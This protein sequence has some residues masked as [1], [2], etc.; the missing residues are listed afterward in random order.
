MKYSGY[1]N[2]PLGKKIGLKPY[3]KLSAIHAPS[4][5]ATHFKPLPQGAAIHTTL[6]ENSDIVHA[7]Y[8]DIESLGKEYPRLVE[9]IHKE[10]MIWISWP[11]KAS[12]VPTDLNRDIIREYVLEQGLVDVKVASYNEVY[13]SLKF[14]YRKKD[15]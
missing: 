1:S 2:T 13:S 12:K 15:R 6:R 7:F 10:G 11:K 5:Y 4:D 8:H 3:F 14:V 9:S